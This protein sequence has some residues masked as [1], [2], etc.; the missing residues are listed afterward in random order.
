MQGDKDISTK[1]DFSAEYI[2]KLAERIKSLRLKAN[3]KSYEA[4]AYDHG[5]S[6]SQWG[7]YE[8]G[9]NLQYIS[10]VKI[11]KAFDMTLEEFFSEGF[12]E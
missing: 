8:K 9:M 5:I 12:E 11:T 3:Y 2:R 6:R 7:R 10:L 4:F 1:E